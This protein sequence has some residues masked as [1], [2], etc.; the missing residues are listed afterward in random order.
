MP[1]FLLGFAI[2]LALGASLEKAFRTER[3]TKFREGMAIVS[4]IWLV[5]TVICTIP[6]VFI[7][8]MTFVDALFESMSA[9]TTTGFSLLDL[10][11]ASM[12]ILFWRSWQQWVGGIGIV[13]LA[14][15]GLFKTGNTLYIIEGHQR[16]K[17]NVINALHTVWWIYIFYTAVGVALLF[18]AG[19]PLFDALNH[20]MTGIA[21]GGMG[22]HAQ[23]IGYYGSAAV[24]A[25]M[26]IVMVLGGISFFVHYQLI[27][28]DRKK[29]LRDTQ[30]IALLL[31]IAAASLVML[32]FH[33]LRESAF[34]AVSAITCSGFQT[35]DL[36][37]WGDYS[38][39]ILAVLMV[40]GGAAGSTVG[41]LKLNRV[42]IFFKS[43][44]DNFRKLLRPRLVPPMRVGNI[45][46]T[47]AE[48][49]AV[50]KFIGIYVL[51]LLITSFV[52]MF[53]GSSAVDSFFQAASA[54]GNVGLSVIPELSIISKCFLIFNMWI[55]RLEIWAVLIFLAY[56]VRGR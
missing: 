44:Y 30:T 46:Y 28:A 54:Q 9:W 17:P 18:A 24:E 8:G 11:S 27:A 47:E 53:Q 40:F 3:E 12:S 25:A 39:S 29:A 43:M 6:F 15:S 26:C 21:T 56:F 2:S 49:Q 55:G 4:C 31:L 1:W 36:T 35:Q 45:N 52:L 50:F 38:K 42:L 37:P 14:L 20:A 13:I 48:L 22:T 34:H 51:F 10:D 41:A 32:P 23:S 19:M 33:G 16:I 5:V 7:E